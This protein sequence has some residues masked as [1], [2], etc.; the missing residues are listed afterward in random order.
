MHH[1]PGRYLDHHRPHHHQNLL[2]HHYPDTNL[3]YLGIRS[4][5]SLANGK[6]DNQFTRRQRRHPGEFRLSRPQQRDGI[7]VNNALVSFLDFCHLLPLVSLSFIEAPALNAPF[8]M[9]VAF[10]LLLNLVNKF[11]IGRAQGGARWTS[12]KA[13]LLQNATPYGQDHP[14]LGSQPVIG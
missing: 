7:L 9:K 3:H 5:K 11:R 6:K 8:T 4:I 12:L 2:W 10:D 14:T 1:H 13:T